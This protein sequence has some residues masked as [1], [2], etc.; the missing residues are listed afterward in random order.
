MPSERPAAKLKSQRPARCIAG[1]YQ[2]PG[3]HQT[4]R[5]V[6]GSHGNGAVRSADAAGGRQE[7][8]TSEV[9]DQRSSEASR[10]EVRAV[11]L[12]VQSQTAHWVLSARYL[13]RFC[14]IL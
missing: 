3:F 10:R 11:L 4:R 13:P 14:S 7:D 6:C 9:T 8:Q 2:P 5:S 12:F 1:L